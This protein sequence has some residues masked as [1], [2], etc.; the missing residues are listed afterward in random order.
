MPFL[1]LSILPNQ[2]VLGKEYDKL[3]KLISHKKNKVA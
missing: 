2:T 3:K 1:W